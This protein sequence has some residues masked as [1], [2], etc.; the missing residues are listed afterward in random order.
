MGVQGNLRWGVWGG[1]WVGGGEGEGGIDS[2]TMQLRR[3]MTMTPAEKERLLAKFNGNPPASAASIRQLE[4]EAG[5]QLPKDYAQ[6]LQQADG[7][8]GFVGNA[9]VILWPVSEL[10]AINR[11]YQVA[12]YAPGLFLFGSDGG[13]E[14]F[15]FDIRASTMPI[16]SVPF[17]GMELK[18]ARL[19]A[20]DF[21]AFLE[22]RFK[23]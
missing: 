7:G 21:P 17:V 22:E 9:Y 6:F 15:A 5:F 20:A 18:V 14:A 1:V 2:A 10:L 12:D 13:G 4:S 3:Q 8:E 23:S 11:A 16:V 19:V